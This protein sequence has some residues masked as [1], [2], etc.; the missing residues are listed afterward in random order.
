MAVSVVI[1]VRNDSRVVDCVSAILSQDTAFPFDIIVVDNQSTDGTSELLHER[2]GMN[3]IVTLTRSGGNLSQAW[4]AGA[5]TTQAPI[6]VR[7]DA[8]AM[9][10]SGWLAAL[11]AP[12]WEGRADWSAGS[13]GGAEPERSLVAR[14]FHSR[15]EAYLRRLG[16]DPEL[17]DAVPSWNVAYTRAA[18]EKAGWYDPWQASSVDWDLHKRLRRAGARGV[19]V[20]EARCLHHHPTTL[21]EF[22]RKEAWYKTGQYQ[23]ALKYGVAEMA[24]AFLLPAAYAF[25]LALILGAI[26]FSPLAWAA[27]AAFALL[28]AKHVQGGLKD[29]DPV[30]YYRAFFRPIEGVAGLFGLLRGIVRY[31]VRRHSTTLTS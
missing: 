22:A 14:Y 11:V 30:W 15:T 9:P 6:L 18:L 7:T 19:Y 31:G 27:L 10:Q 26:V 13:V 20:P 12:L 28:V 25:L 3:P 8:D 29:G 16:R 5:Q 21:R 24:G 4:N 2:L 1:T 23:M 17:R